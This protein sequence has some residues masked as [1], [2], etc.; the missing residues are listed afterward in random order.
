MKKVTAGLMFTCVLTLCSGCSSGYSKAEDA[1][2]EMISAMNDVST[3][4]ESVKDAQ[5]AKAAAPK[6]ESGFDRMQGAKKKLEGIK[7]TKAESEK[8]EK[9]YKTKLMEAATRMQT[10]LLSA[11]LKSGGDA[12]FMKAFEKVK[13]LK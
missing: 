11:G 6:L 9:E 5:T 13:D 8:L 2:K 7:G 1:T 10:A 4:L 12:T 3:A